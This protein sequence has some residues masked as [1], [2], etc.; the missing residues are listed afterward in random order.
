MEF[1]SGQDKCDKCNEKAEDS[2]GLVNRDV[3]LR[4]DR[5]DK[6]FSRNHFHQKQLKTHQYYLGKFLISYSMQFTNIAVS[7]SFCMY[8]FGN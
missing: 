3:A 2:V 7:L 4:R 8:R 6:R 1:I 5:A